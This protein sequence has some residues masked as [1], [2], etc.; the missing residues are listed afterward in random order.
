[1]ILSTLFRYCSLVGQVINPR[2]FP[3]IAKYLQRI[4]LMSILLPP[5]IALQLLHMLC[6][7]VDEVLFPGYRQTRIKAPV[8]VLGVPRSGTT[9]THR[10]LAR[11]SAF[12]TL[13]TW[14]CLFAPSIVQRRL[15]HCVAWLDQR[16]GR[17]LQRTIKILEAKV[18]NWLRDVHPMSLSDAEE[19]YLVLMPLLCCFVL[20]LPFPEAR[21]LWRMGRFDRD[22]PADERNAIMRWHRRCLQK[23]LYVH[24]SQK[25]LLSKNASFASMAISLATEYPDARILVCERDALQTIGSQFKSLNGGMMLF[26]VPVADSHFN[27]QLVQCLL[28]YYQNLDRLTKRID[29]SARVSIP[30]T[31]LSSDPRTVI[32]RIYTMLARPTPPEVEEALCEY[33]S[34]IKQH[35]PLATPNLS[36]WG[37]CEVEIS[38]QFAP[39]LQAAR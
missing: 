1:M 23:H 16:I 32:Q 15:L 11:D 28:F 22:V 37:L 9:F 38:Q 27:V 12:T 25:T 39:W 21:W 18:F 17:P 8:F 30:M 5:F 26:G 19:D 33:E 7:F 20:I 14:E 35:T 29:Q 13:S 6:F 24:G 4:L 36:L 2:H 3:G 34:R 31:L 10:L